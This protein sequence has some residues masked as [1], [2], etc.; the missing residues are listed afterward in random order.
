MNEKNHTL[1]H[2]GNY[3]LDDSTAISGLEGTKAL[4]NKR[5]FGYIRDDKDFTLLQGSPSEDSRFFY[6]NSLLGGRLETG[7][8]D[9]LYNTAF[10]IGLA[11]YKSGLLQ[12]DQTSNGGGHKCACGVKDLSIQDIDSLINELIQ[13]CA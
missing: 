12:L 8:G 1:L 9:K 3:H 4:A 6:E 13:A 11:P 7:E 5:F 2:P 10:S